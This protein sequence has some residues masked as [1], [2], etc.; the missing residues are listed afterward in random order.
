LAWTTTDSLVTEGIQNQ[1]YIANLH[2]S[3]DKERLEGNFADINF[4]LKFIKD[5]NGNYKKYTNYEIV[6]VVQLTNLSKNKFALRPKFR[7][8][9]EIEFKIDS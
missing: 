9:F 6:N 2:I 3:S 4:I 7:L 5:R 8:K 1:I